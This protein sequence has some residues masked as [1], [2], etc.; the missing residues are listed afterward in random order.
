[1]VTVER[2]R[3]WIIEKLFPN[4]VLGQDYMDYHT[5]NS[6]ECGVIVTLA[7]KEFDIIIRAK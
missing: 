2:I 7:G 6:G 3:T 4:P 5:E 1:V